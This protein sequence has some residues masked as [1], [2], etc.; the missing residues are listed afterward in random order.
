MSL[1]GY[2]S[3]TLRSPY[4]LTASVTIASLAAATYYYGHPLASRWRRRETPE[5]ARVQAL[6]RHALSLQV[7][8]TLGAVRGL[9]RSGT[10]SELSAL[11]SVGA[12]EALC[13]AGQLAGQGTPELHAACRD[14]LGRFLLG[15]PPLTPLADLLAV[16]AVFAGGFVLAVEG[17]GPADRLSAALRRGDGA[18]CSSLVYWLLYHSFLAPRSGASASTAETWGTPCQRATAA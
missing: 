5:A 11:L 9:V 12:L 13:L 3:A 1:R 8:P 4:L 17:G 16:T 7:G 15:P 14:Q 6:L 10:A 18:P 2:L